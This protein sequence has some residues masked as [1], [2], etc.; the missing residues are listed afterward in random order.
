MN[1]AEFDSWF[2]ALSSTHVLGLLAPV[3]KRI[4][5][6]S[7][8]NYVIDG[9]IDNLLAFLYQEKYNQVFGEEE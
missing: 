6:C 5:S 3:C 7:G 2:H 9:D 1:K 4:T 8:N